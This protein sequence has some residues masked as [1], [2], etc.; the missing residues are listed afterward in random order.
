M[1]G[2]VW[3]LSQKEIVVS[4][5]PKENSLIDIKTIIK[6]RKKIII[7]GDAAMSNHELYQDIW[8]RG[9]NKECAKK[10]TMP[11]M[12]CL[13]YIMKN[14]DKTVWVNPILKKEWKLVDESG[15]LEKIKKELPMY[16]LTVGG[17][18]DAIKFLMKK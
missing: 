16:D 10:Y 4:S 12:D 8:L 1:Y 3:Q 2:Y 9:D 5:Y 15:V 14:T 6:K 18:Q 7:Y 17:V 11:G 13:R